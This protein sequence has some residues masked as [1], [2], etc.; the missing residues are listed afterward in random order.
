MPTK[1]PPLELLED[2]LLLE[3]LLDEL[4][5]DDELLLEEELLDEDELE[6]L[7]DD[8]LLLPESSDP[9]QPVS[10]TQIASAKD[11]ELKA[12]F[13]FMLLSQCLL[14]SVLGAHSAARNGLKD[15]QQRTSGYRSRRFP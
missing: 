4:L 3:E 7:L 9:P 1:L 2:E 6:L 11:T 14:F 15:A 10:P 8:E 13:E 12:A 5:L